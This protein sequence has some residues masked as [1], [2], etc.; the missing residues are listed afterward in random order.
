MQVN[1]TPLSLPKTN[2]I[3][4]NGGKGVS[5]VASAFIDAIKVTGVEDVSTTSTERMVVVN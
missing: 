3:S 1:I 2:V 4:T 5:I